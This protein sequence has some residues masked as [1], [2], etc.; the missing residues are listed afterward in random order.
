M[1]IDPSRGWDAIAQEFIAARS[2][3]GAEV[4][5]R[6]ARRLPSGGAVVDVGCGSG[7]PVSVVLVEELRRRL[8]SRGHRVLVRHRDTER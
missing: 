7:A 1:A 2:D 5:R 3:I 6:W 8:E 4:V